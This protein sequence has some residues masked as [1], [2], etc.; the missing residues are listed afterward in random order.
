[1]NKPILGCIGQGYIGK[2]YADDFERRGYM[3]VRYA[4]EEEYRG[5]KEKLQDCD[6]V[7]IAVPTPTTPEGFDASI[8]DQ[9]IALVP[10]GKIAVLKST[11]IPGTTSRLQQK[12]PDRIVLV[13]PEFLSEATAAYDAAHPAQNIIGLSID[14]D[15]HRKA[16]A[17][18]LE[19]LPNA[20]HELVCSSTEA[21][22]FKYAH[23]LNGYV[24]IMLSNV[25]YDAA[26]ELGAKW[27]PIQQAIEGD[28]F[29]SG[30][31]AK[32]MHKTGRGAGGHCFIKD[33]A[34]F[35]ELY[36]KLRP[37]DNR[38]LLM[39]KALEQKNQE[40]LVSSGKDLDLLRGVYGNE[41]VD[42]YTNG[43]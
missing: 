10:V 7:F 11:L 27:E 6:I 18:V 17:Q 32:P 35:R 15:A 30:R 3:V 34:A 8:V 38:G 4:L 26:G 20:L 36:Q 14:D 19:I 21:E 23:N 31:Y 29:I 5:N 25:L 9:S 28:P 1:M 33:F 40:L 12:Y 42:T 13:S 39:L 24:Q 2:N 16:A 43:R 37:E 41:I 22:L